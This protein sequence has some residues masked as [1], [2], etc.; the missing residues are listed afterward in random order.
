MSRPKVSA[1]IITYNHAGFIRQAI[2]SVL[3]QQTE[4]EFEILVGEDESSDGTREI[5]EAI[6]A[7]HPGRIRVFLRSRA[8]VITFK[9][10]PTGRFNLTSTLRAASGDY[11]ALLEG[12][13]YWTDPRKLQRQADY[14]DAHPECS[15][16][17]HPVQRIH[18]DG[19]RPPQSSLRPRDKTQFTLGEI[20]AGG[21]HIPT[22]SYFFRRG[23]FGDFPKWYYETEMGDLPLQVL[24]AQHGSTGFL[25][26]E[27]AV[28]RIHAGGAWTA[29]LHMED[30]TADRTRRKLEGF[31]EY[32][33]TIDRVLEGRFGKQIRD[34][35]SMLNYDIV[36]AYQREGDLAM[37]RRYLRAAAG[38]KLLNTSTP[39]S[40]VLKAWAYAFVPGIAA[41]KR[42]LS[43]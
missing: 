21:F 19:T 18:E 16:C 15:A 8:D 7:E 4:F 39:A 14:L 9:G 23:L 29:G 27:M 6:A 22:C 5:V 10:K 26:E 36:W 37:M 20:I 28:Y 25:D 2:E 35:I 24:N 13:D 31:I 34:K 3:M 12:D 40:Y 43:P 33:Q 30:W 17:F 38:A 42:R 32:Y 1:C 41:A 11:I